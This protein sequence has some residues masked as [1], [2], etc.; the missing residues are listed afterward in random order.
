MA[1]SINTASKLHH[2]NLKVFVGSI[3]T[4]W[5]QNIHSQPTGPKKIH[6]SL[7]IVEQKAHVHRPQGISEALWRPHNISPVYRMGV[8]IA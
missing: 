5:I 3:Q 8:H 6:C 4:S 2:N 1:Q 7:S